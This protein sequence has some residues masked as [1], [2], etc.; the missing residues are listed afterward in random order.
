MFTSGVRFLFACCLL[1]TPGCLH[2]PSEPPPPA[3]KPASADKPD[4]GR[5]TMQP[6][7]I[8]PARQ[9]GVE[10]SE[11]DKLSEKKPSAQKEKKTAVS[12][13]KKPAR[14]TEQS[15]ESG[16]DMPAPPPPLR[17][18]TFGGAGG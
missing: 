6:A 17:P 11:K 10:Q 13:E 4:I 2:R 18:P 8:E 7:A 1:Q 5:P 14:K 12:S 9:Q 3:P 16:Q 15:D